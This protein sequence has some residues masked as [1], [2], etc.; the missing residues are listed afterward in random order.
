MGNTTTD[1][2][3]NDVRAGGDVLVA[4]ETLQAAI[5]NVLGVGL[6]PDTAHDA[7]VLLERLEQVS[8]RVDAANVELMD[9]VDSKNL[10]TVDGMLSTKTMVR[11]RTGISSAEAGLRLKVVQ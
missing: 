5:D 11:H 4:V 6:L 1:R 10:C 2:H 8:R 9:R 7:N 3:I